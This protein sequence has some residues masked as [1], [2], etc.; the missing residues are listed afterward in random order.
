M[1]HNTYEYPKSSFL[2]MPKDVS[3]IMRKI[4]GNQNVLRLLYY[5]NPDCLDRTKYP[6]VTTAQVQEMITN[7]QILTVPKVKIDQGDIKRNYLRVTFDSFTPNNTNTFYRDHVVEVRII[8]HFDTW[9]L[10]DFD[11]RPYRLAGEIDAMLADQRLTGIG[12][13]TFLGASQDVYDIEYGGLTLR[14]LAVRGDEDKK[15]PLA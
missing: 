1:Q 11:Q 9:N 3:I 12:L 15:R 5:T 2:G 10:L 8:C 7:E 6:D 13:L 4:L 14:Y